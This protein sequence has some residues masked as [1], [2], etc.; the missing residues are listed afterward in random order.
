MNQLEYLTEKIMEKYGVTLPLDRVALVISKA[1]TTLRNMVGRG[2]GPKSLRKGDRGPHIF[3]ARDVAEWLLGDSPQW[4]LPMA[5]GEK[6]RGRGRP[7]KLTGNKDE[8]VG[9]N[10]V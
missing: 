4:E 2:K 7:R 6:K 10:H 8:N 3:L 5:A 9:G 1:P